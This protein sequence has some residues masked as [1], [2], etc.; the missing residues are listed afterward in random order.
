MKNFLHKIILKLQKYQNRKT[1]NSLLIA[2][3][4]KKGFLLG[5]K[6]ISADNSKFVSIR[7]R[8]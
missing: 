7:L 4:K 5:I 3:V 1:N 6:L 2:C 8:I